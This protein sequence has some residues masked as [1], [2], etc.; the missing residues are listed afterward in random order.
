MKFTKVFPQ[1]TSIFLFCV[2]EQV[3]PALFGDIRHDNNLEDPL[4]T[5]DNRRLIDMIGN[6]NKKL[7]YLQKTQK[8][9]AKQQHQPKR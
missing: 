2:A 5:I 4:R 7:N 1:S 9:Q 6:I 3:L 8:N